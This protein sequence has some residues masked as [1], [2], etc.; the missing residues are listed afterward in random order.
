MYV[1]TC[2]VDLYMCIGIG[3]GG[4]AKGAKAGGG[5]K[6]HGIMTTCLKR[7][8]HRYAAQSQAHARMR[9]DC[10]GFIA[11]NIIILC[12][13]QWGCIALNII[14]LCSSATSCLPLPC[15]YD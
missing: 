6:F 1:Y 11:L 12:L 5:P 9:G 3:T 14:I 7:L 13:R 8:W 10:W 2:A 4:R 15:L